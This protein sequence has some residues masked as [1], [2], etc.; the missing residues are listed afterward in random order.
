MEVHERIKE[1]RKDFLHLSQTEFGEKLGVSRSVINNI[2]RNVL[3]RPDQKLS[4]MKLIC[5]TFNVNEDWLLNG[6]GDMF[7]QPATFCLDDFAAERGATPLELE[8]IKAYFELDPEI[9]KAVIN[10]FKERLS[11]DPAKAKID[12]EVAAYRTDLELEARQES[13]ASDTPDAK[14][15]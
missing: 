5:N 10:H 11:P 15:A 3:A 9:R 2:E 7:A 13:S 1:L 6:T 14:E 8:L 12:K 4:L